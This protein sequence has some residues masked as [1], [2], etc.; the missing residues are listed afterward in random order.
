MMAGIEKGYFPDKATQLAIKNT[1]D[2]IKTTTDVT[3]N[4]RRSASF[5]YRWYEY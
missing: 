3:K 1:V 2:G 5:K 4:R